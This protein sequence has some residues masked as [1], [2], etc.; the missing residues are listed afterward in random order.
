MAPVTASLPTTRLPALDAARS[1][2]LLVGI[3]FHGLES[4]TFV[5]LYNVAQDTQ[6]SPVLE[7]VYYLCHL[8][9]MQLYFLMS[10][11]FA[12]LLYHRR[13]PQEF[14]ANRVQRLLLPFLLFWP[15]NYLLVAGMWLWRLEHT[16]ASTLAQAIAKLPPEFRLAHAV[17]LLHLWFLY[18]LILLCAGVALLRPLLD[19]GP[20]LVRALRHQADQA[21]AWLLSRWWGGLALATL[22]LAPMLR[23]TGGF[24]VDTPDSSLWPQWPPYILYALYF[25]L[26]WLLQRQPALLR[27]FSQFRVANLILASFFV[28]VLFALKL[29]FDFT[30]PVEARWLLPVH[31]FVY[32]FASMTA[33]LACLGYLLVFFSA[34]HSV[35][36]YLSEAAY[37]GYLVHYPIVLFF[38][39]LVA[40]YSW[41]WSIKLLLILA[42]TFLLLLATYQGLV[43]CTWLGQLLNGRRGT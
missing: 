23:M 3:V 28:A 42:P 43:R 18:L 2:A 29:R 15:L 25:G 13:G 41:H 8:F 10:G 35:I 11:F 30:N 39:L 24:G 6:S 7:A 20:S 26:G 21:L 14:V 38:Q 4:L 17:P 34:P 5:K 12:H 31:N 33:L 27:M 32:A 19:R 36:R 40:P 9:R 37:W 16:G 1:L 22:M